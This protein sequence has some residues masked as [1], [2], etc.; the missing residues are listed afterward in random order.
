MQWRLA[1]VVLCLSTQVARCEDQIGPNWKALRPD[2]KVSGQVL[3]GLGMLI[4]VQEVVAQCPL[5]KLPIDAAR[6]R[7]IRRLEEFIVANS[8]QH[9][10]M[11]TFA[12]MQREIGD[13]F[14]KS[15]DH[16]QVCSNPGFDKGFRR[17]EPSE[18]DASVEKMLTTPFDPNQNVPCGP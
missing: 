6:E 10:Q 17:G 9:P 14:R 7:A 5:P 2:S 16:R 11:D 3:C 1:F 18:M 8:S 12:E 13:G 15:P 4:F